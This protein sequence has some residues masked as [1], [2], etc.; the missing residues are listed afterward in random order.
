M[1][2]AYIDEADSPM[3]FAGLYRT[4]ERNF[5]QSE[6]VEID[7]RRSDP[8]IAVPVKSLGVGSRLHESSRYVN[9]GFEPA[10]VKQETAISA[11]N[12]LKRRLGADPFQ[13]PGFLRAAMA[14]A[15][16]TM[17][18]VEA[19]IRRTV[20]LMCAQVFQ[21]GQISLSDENGDLQYE[22]D[23]SAK[24][25]HVV[26]VGVD[27]GPGVG[28]PMDDLRGMAE[29]VRRDGKAEPN[30]LVFGSQAWQN[31][32]A[33]AK[34][35]AALDNRRINLGEVR[36]QA[37]GG[38]A[39]FQGYIWLGDYRFEMWT[40]N[41]TYIDPQTLTHTAYVATDKVI[42]LA[43]EGRRDLTFGEIP[44]F[45]PP[46][47]RAAQFLPRQ[48]NMGA[49]G[50]GLTT[51]AWVTPDGAQLRLMAGTRPLPIP[52]AIDTLGVLDTQA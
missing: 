33:N 28:E 30:M 20:E 11:Y 26:T 16:Q 50:L 12:G 19:K 18:E 31:F 37:N 17:R 29:T 51:N 5:H 10:I 38:G 48:M 4:P 52:T 14:E 34:V 3:F 6:L 36:P 13:D 32:K 47:S 9:K 15:F 21:G 24:A 42:M 41:K 39:T 23:F 27:W 25:T 22:C 35:V 2:E 46:Q 45:M 43:R 44:M 1:L 7:I 40:Y 8:H 49:I